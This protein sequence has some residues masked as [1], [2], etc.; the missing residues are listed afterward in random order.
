M[1]LFSSNNAKS[2]HCYKSTA[3]IY[4][5]ICYYSHQID[6]FL[7]LDLVILWFCVCAC[8]LAAMLRANIVTRAQ[9]EVQD[10]GSKTTNCEIN[11]L[12]QYT[13]I[14]CLKPCLRLPHLYIWIWIIVATR[15]SIIKLPSSKQ[16]GAEAVHSTQ[17][18]HKSTIVLHWSNHVIY[19]STISSVNILQSNERENSRNDHTSMTTLL[20]APQQN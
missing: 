17:K 20:P 2:K 12:E 9:T 3:T 16:H 15:G 18:R 11:K 8:C 19:S 7:Y 6:C 5:K 14:K 1:C 10:Q 4:S 13:E